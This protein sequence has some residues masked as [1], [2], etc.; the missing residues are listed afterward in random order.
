[1]PFWQTV[2]ASVTSGAVLAVVA[3]LLAIYV[4]GR[5]RKK[6]N[7]ATAKRERDLA[8]AA[9]LYRVHGQFYAAWKAW[10]FYF[11]R[12]GHPRIQGVPDDRLRSQAA[13]QAAD[14]EGGYESLILRV[15]FEHDLNDEQE[16]AMWCLR[17]AFK[18]LRYA[19][20]NNQPLQWRRDAKEKPGY[21]DYECFKSLLFIVAEVLIGEDHVEAP[22]DSR[23]RE[24]S[25]RRITGRGAKDLQ[26]TKFKELLAAT[27]REEKAKNTLVSRRSTWIV[28]G[29]QIKSRRDEAAKHT[30]AKSGGGKV[31]VRLE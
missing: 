21:R 16:A 23:T 11:D 17:F 12:E 13:S 20:R 26:D 31:F 8:A 29:E 5:N 10:N 24:Q 1:M 30:T 7:L 14:S 3:T 6:N 28:L 25:A 9:D 19:I 22:S 4:T 2:A 15:A 27:E 18:E